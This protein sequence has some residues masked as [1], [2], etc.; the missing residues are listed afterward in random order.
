MEV[1]Q[2]FHK[3]DKVRIVKYGHSVWVNKTEWKVML[4]A[5]VVKTDKPSH[6]LQE[7]ENIFHYDISP[8]LVGVKASIK[9]SF[10]DIVSGHTP[11]ESGA[12]FIISIC[13]TQKIKQQKKS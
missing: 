5:K 3:D 6:I 9:G 2:K 7:D 1:I 12:K 8:E 11:S 4:Q 13:Q 10:N